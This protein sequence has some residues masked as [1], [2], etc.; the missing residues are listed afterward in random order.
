MHPAGK[1]G[2]TVG[3]VSHAAVVALQ[4]RLSTGFTVVQAAQRLGIDRHRVL[5]LIHEGILTDVLRIAGRWRIPATTLDE[6]LTTVGRLPPLLDRTPDWHSLREATRQFGPS[7]L[8]MARI[9]GLICAGRLSARRDPRETS[10]RGVYLQTSDMVGCADEAIAQDSVTSGWTL[11]RLAK[12]LFP[13]QPLKDVVLRKWIIA[14]LLRGE[15][16]TKQWCIA[17][18]EVVRFRTTYC[19]AKEA[20]RILDISRST[21]ARWE[22]AGQVAPAYSRRTHPTAGASLFRRADVSRLLDRGVA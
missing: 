16:R 22:L 19:L 21:L 10:L 9:V 5:E 18:E 1:R 20:C 4:Q 3:L 17:D 7:H 14:G 15:R 2:R 12:A 11:N 8:N 6:L 13:E